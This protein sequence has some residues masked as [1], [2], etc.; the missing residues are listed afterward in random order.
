ML[1]SCQGKCYT[2]WTCSL[3]CGDTGC[4]GALFKTRKH[5]VLLVPELIQVCHYF[6]AS[7]YHLS[8]VFQDIRLSSSTCQQMIKW[9]KSFGWDN[10]GLW[11]MISWASCSSLLL[12]KLTTKWKW[13]WTHHYHSNIMLKHLQCCVIELIIRF[14]S[15]WVTSKMSL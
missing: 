3:W 6:I 5:V 2:G 10:L 7:T 14:G 15:R 1:E 9:A 11:P 4:Q 8:G 12:I 13:K